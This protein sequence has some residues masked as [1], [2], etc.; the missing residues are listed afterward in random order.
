MKGT[1]STEQS[2]PLASHYIMDHTSSPHFQPFALENHLSF[3]SSF[4]NLYSGV[5]ISYPSSEYNLEINNLTNTSFAL[6]S[7]GLPNLNI[8]SLNQDQLAMFEMSQN[9]S[10]TS[11][12]TNQNYFNVRFSCNYS[13]NSEA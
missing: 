3:Q 12:N 13:L 10:T 6:S 4:S 5:P 11:V 9:T 8:P 7:T 2:G 1:Y